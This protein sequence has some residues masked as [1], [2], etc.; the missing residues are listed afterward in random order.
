MKISHGVLTSFV[1][2]ACSLLSILSARRGTERIRLAG[3]EGGVGRGQP[4]DGRHESQSPR[5]LLNG[6]GR[7]LVNNDTM[8]G[9]PAYGVIQDPTHSGSKFSRPDSAI[10]LP[11]RRYD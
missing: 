5:R 3:G 6:N 10:H 9:D 7:V 4:M 8:G 2:P 1:L 11:G